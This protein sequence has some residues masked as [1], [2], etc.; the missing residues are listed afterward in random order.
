SA[1][2]GVSRDRRKRAAQRRGRRAAE[3]LR[4]ARGAARSG[5]FPLVPRSSII[6]LILEARKLGHKSSVLADDAPDRAADG[7]EGDGVGRDDIAPV[8]I[9]VHVRASSARTACSVSL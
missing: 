5:G 7:D 6:S 9:A 3:R 1:R 8:R 4:A 2:K